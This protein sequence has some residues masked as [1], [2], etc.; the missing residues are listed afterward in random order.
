M[1]DPLLTELQVPICRSRRVLA[2]HSSLVPATLH[3][4]G[5]LAA[6]PCRCPVDFKTAGMIIDDELNALLCNPLPPGVSKLLPAL[7]RARP[8]APCHLGYASSSLSETRLLPAD[9]ACFVA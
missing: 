2:P 5:K 3:L 7:Q 8:N 9:G 1:A 4:T 6:L